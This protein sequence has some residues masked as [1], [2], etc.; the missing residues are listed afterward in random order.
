M[1]DLT[2]SEYEK[3]KDQTTSMFIVFFTVPI[4]AYLCI[5]FVSLPIVKKIMVHK[6]KILLLISRINLRECEKQIFL[7]CNC[8]EVL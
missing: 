2:N 8:I 5:I 1:F 4:I 7:L 3:V 6:E